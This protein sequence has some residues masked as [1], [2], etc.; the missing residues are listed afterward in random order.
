MI[1]EHAEQR[2]LLSHI[3]DALKSKR[4]MDF[5]RMSRRLAQL[6]RNHFDEEDVI[7]CDLAERSLSI[8]EDTMIVT[9]FMKNRVRVESH[10]DLSRVEWKLA[11]RL[12]TGA[13]NAAHEFTHER[14]AD[15][16]R[17]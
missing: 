6:F 2:R 13:L 9:E 16:Y 5:V 17:S 12:Q 8:E 1:L 3:N 7:L 4:A 14:K 10:A 15:L 11:A